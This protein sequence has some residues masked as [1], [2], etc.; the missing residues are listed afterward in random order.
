MVIARKS[1]FLYTFLKVT[2]GGKVLWVRPVTNKAL[3]S[4][5]YRIIMKFFPQPRYRGWKII[6]GTMIGTRLSELKAIKFL[7][8]SALFFGR[9]LGCQV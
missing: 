2:N 1:H 9:R 4:I 7:S 8:I 5:F 6:Q 3:P